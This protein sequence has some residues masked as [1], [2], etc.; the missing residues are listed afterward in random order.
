MSMTN[1]NINLEQLDKLLTNISQAESLTEIGMSLEY[2][3]FN[4]SVLFHYFSTIDDLLEEAI[5]LGQR[6]FV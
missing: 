3:D 2:K 4:S 6:L 5:T 1:Q